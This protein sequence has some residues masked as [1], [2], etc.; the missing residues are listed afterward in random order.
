M[1]RASLTIA[2][3]LATALFAVNVSR[4]QLTESS[5]PESAKVARLP[6][7]KCWDYRFPSSAGPLVAG[8]RDKIFVSEQDGKLRAIAAVSNE[9]LWVSDL[10]GRIEAV[11]PSVQHGVF[12][13]TTSKET[14]DIS[15]PKLR[16]LDL[17][18]GLTKYTSPI[19]ANNVLYLKLAGS[20]ITVFHRS[21]EI[22]SFDGNTGIGVWKARASGRIS[23]EPAVF[24]N[25][26]AISTDAR[27]I[28]F[29]SALDGSI[30][31]TISTPREIKTLAY[32]A[33]QMLVAGDDRGNVT[34]YRDQAGAIWW[35]FKSGGR[36]GPIVET[37][38]GILVGSYDNFVYLI[39]K[40]SGDVKWKRRLDGR[41]T[42]RP[43]VTKK[44][45]IVPVSGS[46]ELVVVDTDLGKILEQTPFGDER[47]PIAEPILS[48][49]G[50]FIFPIAGGLVGFSSSGCK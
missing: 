49:N 22:E 9:T 41:V 4:A 29:I 19:A 5:K 17:D 11:L 13:V 6:L 46:D 14:S 24:E 30:S 26:V 42:Y 21:G 32:R 45:L 37:D 15:L 20:R 33:N 1:L 18:S 25:T 8:V 43:I 3:L 10:G 31:S 23:A 38:D 47:V 16:L 48:D 44:E 27:K 50:M 40:Y 12:V 35:S 7:T 28:D 34:N 2:I 36:I 39:S